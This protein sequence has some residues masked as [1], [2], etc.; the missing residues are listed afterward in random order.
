MFILVINQLDAQ[1]LF[2]N[3]FISSLYM[4]RALCAH[5]QEFKIVL[6]SIWYHHTCRWPSG[7]RDARSAKHQ[8]LWTHVSLYHS[9]MTK[10]ITQVSQGACPSLCTFYCLHSQKLTPRNFYLRTKFPHVQYVCFSV[11]STSEFFPN[12]PLF[13][14]LPPPIWPPQTCNLHNE[15]PIIPLLMLH[16]HNPSDRTMALG[17]TQPL[18][19]MSTRNIRWGVKAAGA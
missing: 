8:N 19:E 15:F 5:H 17:S 12:H 3:K 16:W 18:T 4:F 11:L 6:Y 13:M 7:A 1:N 14:S 10:H 2:Y 9:Y